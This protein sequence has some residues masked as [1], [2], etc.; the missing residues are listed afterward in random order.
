MLTRK[1]YQAIAKIISINTLPLPGSE[2]D[3]LFIIPANL[4]KD[5]AEYCKTDNPN[6]DSR[7]FIEAATKTLED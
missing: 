4:I 2:N 1:Y 6:F 3:G 7:R 5:L